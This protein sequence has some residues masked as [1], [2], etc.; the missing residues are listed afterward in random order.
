VRNENFIL[1]FSI[2]MTLNEKTVGLI[3][4]R[5]MENGLNGDFYDEL[6]ASR[7]SNCRYHRYMSDGERTVWKFMTKRCSLQIEYCWSQMYN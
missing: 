3:G 7:M 5:W 4:T 1:L 2:L 6:Q